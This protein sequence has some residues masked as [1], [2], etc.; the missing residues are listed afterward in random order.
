ML[1]EYSFGKLKR[2]STTLPMSDFL[3]SLPVSA[4]RSPVYLANLN[5]LKHFFSVG[6]SYSRSRKKHPSILN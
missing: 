2:D 1:L 4:S 5:F 3:G 6:K